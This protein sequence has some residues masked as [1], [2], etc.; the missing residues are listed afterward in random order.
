MRR[1][2]VHW[3]GISL[4]LSLSLHSCHDVLVP[5]AN[6][7]AIIDGNNRVQSRESRVPQQ[8]SLAPSSP[9]TRHKIHPH[10]HTL[11]SRVSVWTSEWRKAEGGAHLKNQRRLHSQSGVVYMNVNKIYSLCV[12]RKRLSLFYFGCRRWLHYSLQPQN[13]S[14]KKIETKKLFLFFNNWKPSVH[15]VGG[16]LP[17]SRKLLL[18]QEKA[19]SLNFNEIS[20]FHLDFWLTSPWPNQLKVSL[21][22]PP[23]F[24]SSTTMGWWYYQKVCLPFLAAG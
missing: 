20:F 14:N 1:K 5:F 18:F 19:S 8:A 13:Y 7:I 22:P 15:L 24:L 4:T 12:N 2:I 9:S 11:V 16:Q 23:L 10:T 17:L 6:Q 3:L 21:P